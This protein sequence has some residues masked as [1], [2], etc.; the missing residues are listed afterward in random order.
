MFEAHQTEVVFHTVVG[1]LSLL[2]AAHHAMHCPDEIHAL[3]KKYRRALGGRRAGQILAGLAVI[4]GLTVTLSLP[5]LYVLHGFEA[6]TAS[7]AT[8][9]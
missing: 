2:A 3:L 1:V 8:V 7:G 4:I 5:A 9:A 6:L